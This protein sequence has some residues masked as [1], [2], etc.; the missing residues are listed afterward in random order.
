MEKEIPFVILTAMPPF[1][2]NLFIPIKGEDMYKINLK[3]FYVFGGSIH[4]L[5]KL[6]ANI[7][8][9]DVIVI[10]AN[11]RSELRE[12]LTTINMDAD[13]LPSKWIVP[14]RVNEEVIKRLS[15]FLERLQSKYEEDRSAIL[16][17]DE[18]RELKRRTEEFE[19][20]LGVA[21][22]G[23]ETYYVSQKAIYD[24]TALIERPE[25][26]IPKLIRDRLPAETLFDIKQAG[27]CIAF[28]IPTAAGIHV[29]R[30]VESVIRIYY[31]KV[32]GNLPKRRDRNWGAYSKALTS[33]GG[34]QGIIGSLDHIRENYRNPVIHPESTLEREEA[35]SLF[36]VGMSTIVI[37]MTAI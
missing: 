2:G 31:E 18:V 10:I 21:L 8:I 26:I 30:A 24:T 4:P 3:S 9:D 5:V 20:V 34:D 36:A 37:M 29:I 28:D 27:K 1:S 7:K 12:L 14:I 11:A 13:K 16:R 19:H 25:E 22:D 23:L 6:R 32:I 35:L 17:D 33:K 15:S